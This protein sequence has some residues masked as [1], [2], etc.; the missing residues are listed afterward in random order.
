ML[1]IRST[2]TLFV[3]FSMYLITGFIG[4]PLGAVL[5]SQ[6]PWICLI[7]GLG[8]LILVYPVLIALPD[9]TPEQS[10]IESEDEP[11]LQVE[12]DDQGTE[13]GE[14]ERLE[15]VERTS[16]LQKPKEDSTAIRWQAHV[17]DLVKTQLGD[18]AAL[19]KN[20]KVLLALLSII[21]S[22]GG[23]FRDILLPY[24]SITQDWPLAQVCLLPGSIDIAT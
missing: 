12:E 17:L 13:V 4:P 2:S 6:S 24:L 11:V 1:T 10:I 22:T 16:L 15:I 8:L 7:F 21:I 19:I 5:L 20:K 23:S 9:T 3:V 18:L 14:N